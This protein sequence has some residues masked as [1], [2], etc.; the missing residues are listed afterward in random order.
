MVIPYSNP[1][2]NIG[3]KQA[4]NMKAVVIM[5][6]SPPFLLGQG[7]EPLTE[8]FKGGRRG[9]EGLTRPKFLE[10]VAGKEGVTFFLRRVAVFT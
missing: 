4:L 8:F 10:G 7:F 9:G 5:C 3:K 2:K 1:N 6:I